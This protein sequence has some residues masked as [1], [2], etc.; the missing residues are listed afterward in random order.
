MAVAVARGE[1]AVPDDAVSGRVADQAGK[2]A[3]NHA[4]WSG[5]NGGIAMDDVDTKVVDALCNRTLL[6]QFHLLC[7]ACVLDTRCL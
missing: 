1:A 4:T 5:E 3:C 7:L 2:V 6:L